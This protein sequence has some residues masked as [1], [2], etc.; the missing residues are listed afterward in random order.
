MRRLSTRRPLIVWR[1]D[2]APLLVGACLA[3]SACAPASGGSDPVEVT[4]GS[5][6]QAVDPPRSI[7]APRAEPA[8]RDDA[9]AIT[10]AP[11]P[12]EAEREALRLQRPLLVFVGASW[13]T[14]SLEME[15]TVLTSAAV[16]RAA[17]PY[18]A[19]RVDA[20]DDPAA[21][22]E[23]W[24]QRLDVAGVPSVVLVDATGKRRD[25]IVG[26]VPAPEL[27]SRLNDFISR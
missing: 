25:V 12:A 9:P 8:E 3:S 6:G 24:L 7:D 10:W 19:T 11:D 4:L 2:L 21:A 13:S 27:T 1:R 26:F 5:A 20:T 15:R 22:A 16:R 17:R 18:L 23:Y 14:A